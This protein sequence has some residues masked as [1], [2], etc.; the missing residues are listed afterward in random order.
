[1]SYQISTEKIIQQLIQATPNG[2]EVTLQ[3]GIL[4]VT[5]QLYYHEELFY[6]FSNE[7]RIEFDPQFGLTEE[8]FIQ[9]YPN[10]IWSIEME[11][12]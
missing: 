4:S 6:I 10:T 3:N 8:E 9:N 1:M 5:N 2:L 7:I 11:V 12:S